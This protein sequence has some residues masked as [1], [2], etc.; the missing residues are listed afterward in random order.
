MAKLTLAERQFSKAQ[1]KEEKPEM[2]TNIVAWDLVL[3]HKVCGFQKSHNFGTLG[4][5]DGNARHRRGAD[6]RCEAHRS[7]TL[8]GTNNN[9]CRKERLG[10]SNFLT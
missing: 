4:R 8:S 3:R 2:Y 7:T 10:L 9:L 1:L 5:T 6:C